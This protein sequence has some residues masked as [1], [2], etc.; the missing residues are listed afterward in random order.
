MAKSGGKDLLMEKGEKI[1]LGIATVL[2][3]LFL[4]FGVMA[5][6]N[7]PQNPDDFSKA[8]DGKAASLTTAMNGQATQID[9]VPAPLA[10]PIVLNQVV[11]EPGKNELFDPTQPPDSRRISPTVLPVVEAQAD[12]AVLKVLANDFVLER[13]EQGEVTKVRVGVVTARTDDKVEGGG[14]F[15]KDVKGRFKGKIPRKQQPP[16]FGGGGMPGPGLDPSG[17]GNRGGSGG[18]GPGFPG[19]GGV[20][21]FPGGGGGAMGY[22]GSSS[23]AGGFG[24]GMPGPGGFTGGMPGPGSGF[25]SGAGFP[26]AGGMRG[27][28]GAMPGFP[29]G[30]MFGGSQS[31][32]Q[33]FAVEYIEGENDEEIER[34]LNGRRL[35]IT[36]KPQRMTVIQASIQF[37]GQMTKFRIALNNIELG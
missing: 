36:I 25:G 9:P 21:G 7:R 15:L 32:G 5:M 10:R 3:V 18:P 26:G 6:F 23:P 20:P 30:D 8:V 2:G 35:A 27:G 34:K 24:G 37:R 11:V 13:N 28:S 16:G 31:A 12:I 29:G 1:G 33:R 19:P 17:G 14:Q 22:G 4:G